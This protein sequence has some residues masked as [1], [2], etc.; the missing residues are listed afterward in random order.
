MKLSEIIK[1]SGIKALMPEADSEIKTVCYDSRK[2]AADSLFVCVKGAISDGHKYARSA[3]EKGCR[4][5]VCEYVPEDMPSDASI[6]LCGDTRSALAPIAAAFYAHPEKRMRLVAITG[7]KGKTTT[8]LMIKSILDS[9]GIATGYIGSNGV[10]FAS[11]HYDTVNT[12][13]EG[14]DIYEYLSKM[15]ACGV[16]TAVL[17]VSSQALYMNRVNG[18]LFDICIFTNFSKDHIGGNEHPDMDHYKACK[19]KLFSEHLRGTALINADDPVSEDFARAAIRSG[20]DILRF[21]TLQKADFY[22]ENISYT[23]DEHGLGASFAL[24]AN[25]E[26]YSIVHHFPGDF[27]VANAIAAAAV[28][29]LCGAELHHVAKA[30][31]DISIKG[32]FE[33]MRVGGVDFVIDYAHNGKSLRSVLEV[34]RTYN[35]HRLICLYGSVGGRTHMRRAEL[36]KVASELADFSILTSDNPDCESPKK[37]IADIAAQYADKSSYISIPDRK[38]AIEYAVEIARAGDIVLLAGKGHEDYQLING[39]RE[40]FCEREIILNASEALV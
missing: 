17:E 36:G 28:C 40:P 19:L 23:R 6:V 38:R 24:N 1:N 25:G 8:A 22:S 14:C 30:F 4:C 29:K 35:P 18:L 33:A 10:D 16:N 34:L 21:S 12:T 32:R 2:A 37:I 39:R 11:F 5:F 26:R 20:N 9:C 27:G 7:T 3:Y 31:F 13:P 15:C